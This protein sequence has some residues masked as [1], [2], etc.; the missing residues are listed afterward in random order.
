METASLKYCHCAHTFHANW[1]F[2]WGKNLKYFGNSSGGSHY[3]RLPICVL[4]LIGLSAVEENELNDS[5]SANSTGFTV[6]SRRRGGKRTVV[7]TAV[8]PSSVKPPTRLLEKKIGHELQCE[9]F[10][11]WLT[12]LEAL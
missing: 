6:R 7:N 1:I 12:W 5:L 10:H 8:V 11:L 4:A 2:F 9:S 3:F